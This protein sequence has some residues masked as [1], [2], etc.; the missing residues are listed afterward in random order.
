MIGINLPYV[1]FKSIY[2]TRSTFLE[3][4]SLMRDIIFAYEKSLYGD[5]LYSFAVYFFSQMNN[6]VGPHKILMCENIGDGLTSG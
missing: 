6:L 1:R 4:K 2:R 5:E 3:L